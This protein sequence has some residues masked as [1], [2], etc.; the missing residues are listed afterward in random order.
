MSLQHVIAHIVAT[1]GS[2]GDCQPQT[3]SRSILQSLEE[4]NGII[5]VS[6]KVL[7]LRNSQ[8]MPR[9]RQ[10]VLVQRHARQIEDA[11]LDLLRARTITIHAAVSSAMASVFSTL[12]VVAEIRELQFL[13]QQLSLIAVDKDAVGD[14]R[15]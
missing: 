13:Q 11:L 3:F 7:S 4:L 9:N 10:Q 5:K 6:E 2:I 15:A 14:N 8:I 12:Y 1:I